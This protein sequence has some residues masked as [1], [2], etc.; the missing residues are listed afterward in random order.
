MGF[1]VERYNMYSKQ[2]ECV[3]LL[4]APYPGMMQWCSTAVLWLICYKFYLWMAIQQD[5]QKLLQIRHMVGH[6]V[7]VLYIQI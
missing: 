1:V 7:S 3:T 5:Q 2:M 6:D 4:F